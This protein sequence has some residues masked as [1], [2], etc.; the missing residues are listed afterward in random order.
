VSSQPTWARWVKWIS[1]AVA[2]PA[3]IF[4]IHQ[5]GLRT[6]GHYLHRIGWWWLAIIPMEM[7]CTT[8]HATAM[9]Y[10][11]SP[12]TDKLRLRDTLLAQLSGRAINSVTPTG[13]LGE[14]VKMSILTEYVSQSRAVATVL[15]YNV[16]SFAAELGIVGVAAPIL[17]FIVPTT[18]GVRWLIFGAGIACLLVSLFV[19]LVVRKGMLA[20]LAR[21]GRRVR[22]VSPARFE[23]W[24][25]KLHAIDDKLRLV[26]GARKR[27]RAIGI[28]ALT[29]S[30]LNAFA[31]SFMLLHALGEP[32]TLGFVTAFVVGGTVIY[33]L[34]SLVPMGIGLSEGGYYGLFRALGESTHRGVALVI[35]RRSIVIMYAI[36]GL[37]LATV[38]ET[39]KRAKESHAAAQQA[40]AAAPEPVRTPVPV[41]Q[42]TGTDA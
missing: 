27:D 17:A 5:T 13:N 42:E 12:E 3:L 19:F 40:P 30:R 8:L 7:L 16:V 15:L 11:A 1:L 14:L 2:I 26:A 18:T 24:E 33:Y 20:G 4:T 28:V 38:S 29:A 23:A 32:L 22:L 37:L 31:L 25:P 39:V 6:L 21:L 34:G 41:L 10:F 36:V 9:R 35:A